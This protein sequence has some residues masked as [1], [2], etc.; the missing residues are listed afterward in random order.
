MTQD[1]DERALAD[2]CLPFLRKGPLSTLEIKARLGGDADS[3]AIYRA[4][5]KDER[6]HAKPWGSVTAFEVKARSGSSML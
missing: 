2:R 1:K 4:L 5:A 6:V 3:S